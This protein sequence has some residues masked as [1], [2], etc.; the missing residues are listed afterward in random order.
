MKESFYPIEALAFYFFLAHFDE[1]DTIHDMIFLIF[2]YL[3]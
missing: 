3:M 2:D 1:N